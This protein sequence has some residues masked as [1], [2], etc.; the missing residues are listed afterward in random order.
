MSEQ[1]GGKYEK[2]DWNIIQTE[3]GMEK[4]QYTQALIMQL[5]EINKI[6]SRLAETPPDLHR[7][8]MELTKLA[9]SLSDDD[10][11]PNRNNFITAVSILESCFYP[12]INGVVK[13]E[14]DKLNEGH[15]NKTKCPYCKLG[16]MDDLRTAWLKHRI[17]LRGMHMKGLLPVE[18]LNY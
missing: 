1:K 13:E 16:E 18:G 11:K 4:L 7:I 2:G 6:A 15:A 10:L 12:Y 8:N 3:T 9:T 5:I 14:L 17:L